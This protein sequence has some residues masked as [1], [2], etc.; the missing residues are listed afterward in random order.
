MRRTLA[1]YQFFFM[2][3]SGTASFYSFFLVGAFRSKISRDVQPEQRLSYRYLN[4]SKLISR[5]GESD[6]QLHK[7]NKITNL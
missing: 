7:Y 6:I 2:L 4:T 1:S 5:R 3:E